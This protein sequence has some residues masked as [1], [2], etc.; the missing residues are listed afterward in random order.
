MCL[1]FLATQDVSG[2]PS[3]EQIR[4]ALVKAQDEMRNEKTMPPQVEKDVAE[5]LADTLSEGDKDKDDLDLLSTDDDVAGETQNKGKKRKDTPASSHAE[6]GEALPKASPAEASD[7]QV[8]KDK[9]SKKDKKDKK[10]R[11][12]RKTR[13]SPRNDLSVL[14]WVLFRWKRKVRA[15]G[16]RDYATAIS[17]T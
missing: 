16:P 10:T 2:R 14:P 9:T 17:E 3:K 15:L 6:P 4:E 7:S 12:T 11:K 13:A 8:A 5:D 1:C